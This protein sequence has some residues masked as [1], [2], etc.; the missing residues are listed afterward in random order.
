MKLGNKIL[1]NPLRSLFLQFE[2]NV[3][4]SVKGFVLV[5][6]CRHYYNYRTYSALILGMSN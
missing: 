5:K 2:E 1:K 3:T 6:I 4:S